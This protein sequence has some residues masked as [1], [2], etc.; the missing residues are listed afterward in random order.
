MKKMIAIGLLHALCA[1]PTQAAP[2]LPDV[3]TL[4]VSVR[5][6]YPPEL[7]TISQAVDWL[8]EPLGYYVITD[9]PAP[10]SAKMLLAQ[11]IPPAA[12]MHRTM[13]VLHALQLLIGED[14]T[15]IVDKQNRLITFSRGH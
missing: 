13:P 5:T 2:R 12:K 4:Q 14:N 8:I 11:P 1:L 9:Y 6:I 7:S 15:I 10:E 3:D